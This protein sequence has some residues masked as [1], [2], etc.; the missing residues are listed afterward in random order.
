MTASWIF[1][2]IS[3]FGW[4]N[5]MAEIIPHK[6]RAYFFG[7]RSN[8]SN[9]VNIGW[10][11]LVSGILDAV[12]GSALYYAYAV[13]FL[14]G[15]I[16][17]LADILLHIFIPEIHQRTESDSGDIS[18]SEFLEPLRNRNFIGLCLSVGVVLSP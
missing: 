13:I 5:W 18:L 16:G 14:V 6:I 3:A 8:V 1:T 11:F 10:F 7:R 15:G 17:G 12:S 4:W 9:I 2:N